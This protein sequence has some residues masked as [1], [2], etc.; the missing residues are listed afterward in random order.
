[1]NYDQPS[2]YQFSHDSVFL[3]R[4]VFDFVQSQNLPITHVLDLCAGCGIIGLDFLYHLIASNSPLPKSIDF[5]EV[6][7]VYLSYF[8]KNINRL[9]ISVSHQFLHLNYKDLPLQP[10]LKNKYDL[11]VCN[12][13]YFR[14]EQGKLS[15]SDFK[16]RC[17]FYIDADFQNLLLSIQYALSKIGTAYVLIRSLEDHGIRV[18]DEIQSFQ[19]NLRIKKINQIRSTDL[20]EIKKI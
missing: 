5:I 4:A 19:H 2:E 6:Q 12:P 3:A 8:K 14:K 15:P 20:Y 13:P 16:N 7:N 9:N 11:I 1:M 10:H 18:E 17:R